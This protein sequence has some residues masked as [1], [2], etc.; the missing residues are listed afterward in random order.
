[1]DG[2]N[3]LVLNSGEYKEPLK[4]AYNSGRSLSF[5]SPTIGEWLRFAS[6]TSLV[7]DE[8]IG[9]ASKFEPLIESD[10]N[11]GIILRTVQYWDNLCARNAGVIWTSKDRATKFNFLAVD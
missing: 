4:L 2:R 6:A 3:E 5:Y 9:G 7:F 8:S 10:G 11:D 1:M